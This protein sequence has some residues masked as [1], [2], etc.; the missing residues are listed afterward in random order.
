[1][2][3]VNKFNMVVLVLIAFFTLCFGSVACGEEGKKENKKKKDH[4]VEKEPRKLAEQRK[5]RKQLE[6]EQKRELKAHIRVLKNSI[7]TLKNL[8]VK[9]TRLAGSKAKNIADNEISWIELKNLPLNFGWEERKR[10]AEEKNQE[11]K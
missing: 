10:L 9:L 2:R 7:N 4:E 3:S 8:I 11:K 6:E 1:M 5:A